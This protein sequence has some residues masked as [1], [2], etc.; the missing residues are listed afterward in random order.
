MNTGLLHAVEV[1]GWAGVAAF[2]SASAESFATGMPADLASKTWWVH[3]AVIAGTA[4]I[5]AA[6]KALAGELD[7][8]PS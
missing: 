8:D 3:T 1:I 6:R 5:V 7:P 4:A 2:V